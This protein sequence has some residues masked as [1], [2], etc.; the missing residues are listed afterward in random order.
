MALVGGAG[1]AFIGKVHV[2]AATLDRQAELVAGAFSS[3]PERSRE[4]TAAF[5]V[6]PARGYASY[7]DLI[8]GE[9]RLPADKRVDFISIATPNHTHCAIAK[10]AIQAGFHVV[11]DKPMT[12][13]VA[14]ARELV[15]LVE[16]SGVVFALTHN[17][18]GY[19]MVRQAREI[20]AAGELGEV[21]AIRSS[22]LQGWMR[23]MD[24]QAKPARGAWKSDPEKAGSGSLGDIGT[25]AYHLAR[26]V[27]GLQPVA[28]SA[29]FK[30][31]REDWEMED[32]GHVLVRLENN[33]VALVTFSQVTHGNLNNITLEV[34]GTKGSLSWHQEEPNTLTIRRFGKPVETY[35][36]HPFADYMAPTARQSCRLAGGHPEGFFEAFAN[37]YQNAFADMHACYRGETPDR[38]NPL[39][40]NVYDGL[41]GVRFVETC[42]R[43]NADGNAWQEFC[44]G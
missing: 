10:A 34:D 41:E 29:H 20:I 40:P 24:P 9:S 38:H 22:Y 32:Y 42:Q 15:S 43:S 6:D 12:T 21:Q 5:Q 8:A 2:T 17:Y 25:H 33:A 7:S 14:E 19:P 30:S 35:H 36:C 18:S 1:A 44:I 13:N 4:A 23:G 37:I 3:D 31:F 26:F 27:S 28:A 16:Q 39:Y 11:C